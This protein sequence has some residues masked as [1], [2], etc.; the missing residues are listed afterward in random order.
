MLTVKDD[1]VTTIYPFAHEGEE[2][3]NMTAQVMI[4]P[5]GGIKLWMAQNLMDAE[6]AEMMSD[7]LLHAVGI[8]KNGQNK[9]KINDL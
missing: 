8:V 9:P 4:F 3:T 7:A 1:N 6:R 2:P 5:G